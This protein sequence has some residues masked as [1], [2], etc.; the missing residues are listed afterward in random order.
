M[1]CHFLTCVLCLAAWHL[2]C[3]PGAM[4]APLCG[5]SFLHCRGPE[6]SPS[7][8]VRVLGQ[9]PTAQHPACHPGQGS[10]KCLKEVGMGSQPGTHVATLPAL[11]AARGLQLPGLQEIMLKLARASFDICKPRS[12]PGT[13]AHITCYKNLYFYQKMYCTYTTTSHG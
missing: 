7:Q 6:G 1:G 2:Y 10:I 9:D 13:G 5:E 3:L 8:T 4:A 11:S 12:S